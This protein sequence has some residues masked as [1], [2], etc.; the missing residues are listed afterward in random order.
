MK[1]VKYIEKFVELLTESENTDIAASRAFGLIAK[2]YC[3]GRVFMEFIAPSTLYTK[4]GDRRELL[5]FKADGAIEEEAR[6]FREFHTGEGGTVKYFLYGE[7]GADTLSEE[8]KRELDLFFDILF[9]HCG[10]WRLINH[11][12]KLSLTDSLTG[13][14]NSGGFLSYIEERLNKKELTRYNAYY[15]NLARFCLI[16]ERFGVKETD[17]IIVRYSQELLKFLKDG[18]CIGRLGGDNFVAL[19]LKERTSAFLE[20]L[21]G[22]ETYGMLGNR[23][24][25]ICISAAEKTAGGWIC[26]SN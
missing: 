20:L 11:V 14:P 16:N 23:R 8:E 18:E 2:E 13:L 5:L 1:Y 10:R 15:F 6:Y 3:I 17:T 9:F 22:V 12:K 7:K 24:I 25:S 26:R 19:I 21:S 4:G